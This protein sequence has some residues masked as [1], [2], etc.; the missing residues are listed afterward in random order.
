MIGF[1]LERFANS[2]PNLD[3]VTVYFDNLVVKNGTLAMISMRYFYSIVNTCTSKWT[4]NG[5]FKLKLVRPGKKERVYDAQ[6]RKNA[7][8][9]PASFRWT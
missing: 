1:N 5:K 8:P 2:P 6:T 3:H 4:R 9:D 7:N